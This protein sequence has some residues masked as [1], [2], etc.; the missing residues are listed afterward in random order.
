MYHINLGTPN[1]KKMK[2]SIN[3]NMDIKILLSF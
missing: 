1:N 3:V 2:L